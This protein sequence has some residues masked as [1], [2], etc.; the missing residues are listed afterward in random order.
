MQNKM[1]RFLTSLGLVDPERFDLDFELVGRDAANPKKVI[2]AIRKDTPWDMTLL[3]EFQTALAG[4]KYDYTMRFSYDK[5][6]D[7]DSVD[8]LFEDWYLTHYHGIPPFQLT[9]GDGGEINTFL[10]E[11]FSKGTANEI[12]ADF[13]AL[14]KYLS[15]PFVVSVQE[16][17]IPAPAPIKAPAYQPELVVVAAS[18]AK[19]L[20]EDRK[21]PAAP[22]AKPV[23]EVKP[24][25]EAQPV[26]AVKPAPEATMAPEPKKEESPANPS[27]NSQNRAGNETPEKGEDEDEDSEDEEKGSCETPAN[28]GADDVPPMSED[29]LNHQ[30]ALAQAEQNYIETSKIAMR[31]EA[32]SRIFFKGDYHE[33]ST[34]A[35]LFDISSGNVQFEGNVFLTNFRV[36]RRGGLYGTIGVGDASSAINVR[37]TESRNGMSAEFLNALKVGDVVKGSRSD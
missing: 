10:P 23:D 8:Q 20:V 17:D 5:T 33:V 11:D 37:A 28:N 15:Y 22:E 14:L 31:A 32:N 16:G 29:E 21:A 19:P 30:S 35:E 3:D 34:I 25:P 9:P 12:V 2:M 27:S 1:L 6:P 24:V 13:N 7:F 18:E 36:G 26:Q 4:V